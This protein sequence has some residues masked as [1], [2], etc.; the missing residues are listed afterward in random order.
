LEGKKSFSKVEDIAADFIK[1]IQALQPEGPYLLGGFSFGSKVAFE[2]AHQL[3][4]QG[5]EVRLLALLDP[6]IIHNAKRSAAVSSISSTFSG[7]ITLFCAELHRR[8]CKDKVLKPQQKLTFLWNGLR[9][10]VDGKIANIR[11]EIKKIECWFYLSTG[12]RLP[13]ALRSFYFGEVSRRAELQYIPYVYP[14]RLIVFPTEEMSTETQLEWGKL[15]G[16]G[17]EVHVVPGNHHTIMKESGVRLWAE[18]LK[19]Y[20]DE[21]QQQYT[22]KNFSASR[23]SDWFKLNCPNAG[24]RGQNTQRCEGKI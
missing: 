4:K 8:L 7:R 13:P 10:R 15:A 23:K 20:L 14:G 24:D 2:M 21:A 17:M 6:G 12:L 5:H 16:G 19:A 22:S 9:W 11:K 1:E 18:Q 3:R